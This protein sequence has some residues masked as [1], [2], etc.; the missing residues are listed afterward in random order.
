VSTT[1]EA[2]AALDSLIHDNEE[3]VVENSRLRLKLETVQ[4]Q[5]HTAAVLADRRGW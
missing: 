2:Y 4:N 3:L 5:L 1:A